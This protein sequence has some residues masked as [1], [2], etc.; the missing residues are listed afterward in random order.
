MGDSMQ[1]P[2]S[3]MIWGWSNCCIMYASSRNLSTLKEQCRMNG[4][5]IL[6]TTKGF[7]G[8]PSILLGD[9]S[10]YNS[11]Y[12]TSKYLKVSQ[13]H[14]LKYI[15]SPKMNSN[16]QH[17]HWM[18]HSHTVTNLLKEEEYFSVLTATWRRSP[19]SV[20]KVPRWTSPNWPSPITSLTCTRDLGN[21]REYS[22][23]IS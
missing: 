8:P 13:K 9:W 16:K 12:S 3:L 21:K 19:T 4:S 11:D 14:R 5:Y 6:Y 23:E 18:N 2:S 22:N 15:L 7:R 17:W 20:S 1:T 10:K